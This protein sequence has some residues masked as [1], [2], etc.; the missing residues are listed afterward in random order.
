M[1]T[2]KRYP[3][4]QRRGAKQTLDLSAA[5]NA[6]F[7]TQKPTQESLAA[8]MED[9]AEFSGYFTV[10]SSSASTNELWELNGK[11]AVFAR[12]LSLIT[13]SEYEREQLRA[14]ALLEMQISNVEGE[15]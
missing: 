13:L 12:I 8:V 5:Y 3:E 7:T 11:R 15:R 1:T 2:D 14:R 9:L 6:V 4:G 10:A